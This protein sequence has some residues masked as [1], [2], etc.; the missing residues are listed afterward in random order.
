[1]NYWAEMEGYREILKDIEVCRKYGKNYL[2][3]KGKWAEYVE[4]LHPRKIQL[5][6]ADI[7]PETSSAKTLRL[8]SAEKYLPP[9][10]AGQY[11][12]LSVVIDGIRTSRPYSI[13]SSPNQSGFYDITVKRIDN[14]FVS[15]YLLDKVQ[16]GDIIEAGSPTGNFYYNPLFH[17]KDLV[18][19]A[20]GSG[21]TP[22]MSMI[23]QVTDCGRDLN[24]RLLYGNRSIDEVLFHEEL[25]ERA[26]HYSN[27]SYELII[28]DPPADYKGISGFI[29]SS[30]I[31][32]LSGDIKDKTFYLCGPAAMYNYCL[33]ELQ[34]LEVPE[35][36]IRHEVFGMPSDVTLMP[37]W[38]DNINS[39][40]EVGVKV[41]GQGLSTPLFIK[42]KATEPLLTALERNG[43]QTPSSCRAGECSMC[44]VKLLSGNVF[45]VAGKVRK[46][47]LEYGFI[48]SCSSYPITDLEIL[49]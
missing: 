19:I 27:F 48:H 11:I 32:Q 20:G 36:K 12:N 1:M 9:F 23:R 47:D 18:F 33:A 30:V 22:F 5:K 4:R 45:Q 43:I 7:I 49:L 17:G 24:I 2:A 38:P 41:R 14:G 6:V 29:D 46:S 3:D 40:T 39:L 37:G 44:R 34:K 15:D 31:K 28:S 13:S 10:Q 8:V 26:K 42:A 25:Q 16:V 35:R 21:I